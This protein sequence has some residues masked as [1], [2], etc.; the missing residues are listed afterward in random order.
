MSVSHK[1]FLNSAEELLNNKESIEIDF[2]NL[3]S[4]SYYA[5]FLLAREKSQNLPTPENINLKKLGSHEKVIDSFKENTDKRLK[6]IGQILQ[7]LKLKRCV[8]DYEI[9]LDIKRAESAQHFHTS[10]G[11]ISKLEN[12]NSIDST[13]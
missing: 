11:L 6:Q 10:K 5:T 9:H 8:A 3:I 2:R 1:D 4:R 7:Q 13:V 12:L